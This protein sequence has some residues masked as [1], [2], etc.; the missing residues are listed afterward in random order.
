MLVALCVSIMPAAAYARYESVSQRAH[1]IPDSAGA[2]A[3]CPFMNEMLPKQAKQSED[4][5]GKGDDCSL[6]ACFLKCFHSPDIGVSVVEVSDLPLCFEVEN[7]SP[8]LFPPHEPPT[9]PPQI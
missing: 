8:P 6:A 4:V 1:T 7:F 3:D 9:P 2:M 5:P